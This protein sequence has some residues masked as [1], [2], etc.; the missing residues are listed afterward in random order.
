MNGVNMQQI[1]NTI[2]MS[3]DKSVGEI[4]D[5]VKKEIV[6][7]PNPLWKKKVNVTLTYA[8]WTSV[9]NFCDFPTPKPTHITDQI[10]KAID[11]QTSKKKTE[12]VKENP[13]LFDDA[14]EEE[15]EP[16]IKA[17]A[18]VED[19]CEECN[20]PIEITGMVSV[21]YFN[22]K[23]CCGP[24]V[25]NIMEGKKNECIVNKKPPTPPTPIQSDSSEEEEDEIQEEINLSTVWKQLIQ[26]LT[27]YGITKASKTQTY[28]LQRNL[29][30]S[31]IY[32]I[33]TTKK[34]VIIRFF[35]DEHLYK[36]IGKNIFPKQN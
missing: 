5:E 36:E 10:R 16:V 19:I 34:S 1:G 23:K 31:F 15:D 4:M 27:K 2:D 29:K 12:P 20:K 18:V 7:K 9:L 11:E 33:H 17:V 26:D 22:N 25:L 6:K 13:E 21:C 30:K 32:K 8:E 3:K 28:S 14:E 24:C 35:N